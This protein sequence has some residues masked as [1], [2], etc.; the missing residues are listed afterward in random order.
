MRTQ[1]IL[2]LLCLYVSSVC[3]AQ[4]TGEI[5]QENP[6]A[7]EKTYPAATEELE[8]ENGV[9]PSL[10]EIYRNR[11]LAKAIMKDRAGAIADY[12]K[13]LELESDS[14]TFYNRGLLRAQI[15]DYTGAFE[16]F[17]QAFETEKNNSEFYLLRGICK[18]LTQEY[19]A[20]IAELN[21]ALEL[22]N[23][24]VKA[25]YFRALAELNLKQKEAA[26]G[27]LQKAK[28]LGYSKADELIQK[29]CK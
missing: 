26:C 16:D 14:R 8:K 11:A 15:S 6:K 19:M 18:S 7:K 21:K 9:A 12:T 13:S 29:Y 3:F 23:S 20:S 24:L 28:N 4:S 25:Y 22:D 17:D 2:L 1:S 10:V 27:D 5:L